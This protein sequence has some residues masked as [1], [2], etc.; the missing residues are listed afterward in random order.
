MKGHSILM[1]FIFIIRRPKM[2]KVAA[3]PAVPF[4]VHY[5]SVREQ[6]YISWFSRET[7]MNERG[8]KFTLLQIDIYLIYP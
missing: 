8:A 4:F 7:N 6:K 2:V 5:I 3:V 1:F